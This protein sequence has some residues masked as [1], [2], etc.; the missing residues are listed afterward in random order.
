MEVLN[1]AGRIGVLDSGPDSG[2]GEEGELP[3]E[4]RGLPGAPSD[5]SLQGLNHSTW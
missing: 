5:V 4:T 2:N 3:D 1:D